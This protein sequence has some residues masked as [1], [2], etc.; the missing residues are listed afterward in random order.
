MTASTSRRK[1]LQQVSAIGLG[2][3]GLPLFRGL[4]FGQEPRTGEAIAI[5]SRRELFVD[6]F[7]IETL[8]GASI[9]PHKPEPREVVL[10]FDAPWEGNT[11]AYVTIFQ[12]GDRF[13]AYYRG[14]HYDEAAKKSAHR[15]VACYAESRDGLK[16]EK[17]PLGIF[18]FNGSK[19]NNIIWMGNIGVHNFT[20]FKDDNPA[21]KPEARYKAL[22]SGN[23][24]HQPDNRKQYGLFAFQSPDGVHWSLMSERLVITDGLFDSQ[25]LAFWDG[26]RQQYFAFHRQLRNKVR[27]IK[28]STSQDFLTWTQPEFLDYGDAPTEHLYTNAIRPYFRA[29]HLFIGFPTRFQPKTQQVEPI[30]MSSRDG[31]RFR[32]GGEALI[33]ITAPQDRDGNRSNY[34]VN[35]LIQVP[36]QDREL[37]V[38][39]TEAYYTGPGSRVRRFAFRTDGF[40]SVH[41]PSAGGRLVTK[42][43]SFAGSRLSLNI[44]SRGPSRVEVQDATGRPI[45]G[46]SGGDC[47]P[48]QG[49]FI[50][51]PVSWKGGSV[52]GL[53]GKPVKLVFEL[54]DADI[55]AFQFSKG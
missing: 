10:V 50:D 17:P 14:A 30:S 31:R 33:P 5:G 15:E 34:M 22:G 2:I 19:Q 1:W 12:D 41:A 47:A 9:T 32:R 40:T 24:F 45:A 7:L 51:H 13:R 39:G 28:V 3:G 25:N 21:C 16:W 6:D 11:S 23:Y 37:S 48:I 44:A 52:A 8:R 35:G 55:Y 36:G 43:I 53:A 46:F 49:D 54:S 4:S 42:P 29:P 38:F 26:E 27:D 20:P 18:E